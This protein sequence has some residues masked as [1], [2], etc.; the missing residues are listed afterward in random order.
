MPVIPLRGITIFPNMVLHFDVGRDKSIKALEEA[1]ISDQTIFLT[2][3]M[4]PETDLPTEEDFYKVGTV[5]QIKQM[6]KLP[7]DVVRVLVDGICRGRIDSIIQDDPYFKCSI[8][9]YYDLEKL[10]MT[11]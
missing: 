6:L 11:E 4:N 2:T 1:M 5:S 8:D 9:E 10:E 7:G 3:Q